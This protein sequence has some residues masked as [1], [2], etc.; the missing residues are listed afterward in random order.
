MTIEIPIEFKRLFDRD[1][2]EAAVFGGR[3][4]LKS[5]T[6]AR[7]LLIRARQ[8]KTRV[9]CFREMQNSIAESSHQLLKDLIDKYKLK[10][11]EVTENSIVNRI[12]G[13]DFLF[14][15]LHRNEQSIKSIEG[16]DIA[17]CEES[18]SMSES[19]IEV[20]TP[21]VRKPGSQI[22][23][24]Y[25]RLEEEDPVHKRLVIEGRPN[26]LI[27]NVNYHTALKYG[28]MPE[29]MRLE[30]EDDKERRPSLYRHK[31]LGEPNKNME[32]RIYKDWSVID[33]V[34]HE[35][36][37]VRYG[38]DFGY[39]NDPSALVAIYSYNGGYIL[40]ELLYLKG[41]SN[42]QIAD[43]ILAQKEHVLVVGDSSEPKS[44][45]EIKS[46]GVSIVGAKKQRE[47]TGTYKTYNAWAIA[48]VQDKRISITKRSLNGRREYNTYYWMVD[49]DGKI[50]NIPEY[51]NN[52]FLD[53]SKY[54][55]ISLIDATPESV[56]NRQE[57]T[58]NQNFNLQ[59]LNSTL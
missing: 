57:D 6:V 50:L 56:L 40:D 51:F 38:L 4:S 26:T 31:W 55:L 34:P 35:A 28:M 58:F 36:K 20:L 48:Q 25:N 30:M 32:R 19:S 52:H 24:T 54:A 14:K 3:F 27:I 15:G 59:T 17:W 22:I 41:Q 43:V 53:A 2:R 47:K 11:F 29:E 13:S 39:S 37:L 33:D 9:G 8:E 49:K 10:E 16:I 18:Q 45:D 42:K 12:N 7:F 21:T 23:Y 1:W 46:Y 44:I 5:H